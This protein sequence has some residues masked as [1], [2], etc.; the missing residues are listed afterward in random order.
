MNRNS[1]LLASS[2]L[3]VLLGV[4][5]VYLGT[6]KRMMP[7]TITGIGFIVIAIAFLSLRRK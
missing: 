2:V 1:T 3:L 7:P 5:M 4:Y 6:T